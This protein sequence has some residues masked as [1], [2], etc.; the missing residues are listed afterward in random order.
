MLK[1]KIR[2]SEQISLPSLDELRGTADDKLRCKCG[3]FLGNSN[4]GGSNGKLNDSG[5]GECHC[6][7]CVCKM[8]V[9][10]C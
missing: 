4:L 6:E 7:N 8:E 1:S 3:K 5:R 2:Y 9:L 10:P